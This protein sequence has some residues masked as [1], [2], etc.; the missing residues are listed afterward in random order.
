MAIS[1]SPS[2]SQRV[3][4][5]LEHSIQ[6]NSLRA[7]QK[8][9]EL[10]LSKTSIFEDSLKSFQKRIDVYIDRISKSKAAPFPTNVVLP[11]HEEIAKLR[12]LI[13]PL[14]D[15]TSREKI[16]IYHFCCDAIEKTKDKLG[17]TDKQNILDFIDSQNKILNMTKDLIAQILFLFDR[18]RV[19]LVKI[20]NEASA[21][22]FTEIDVL[23][24]NTLGNLAIHPDLAIKKRKFIEIASILITQ[25]GKLNLKMIPY[26]F[27]YFLSDDLESL[28]RILSSLNSDWQVEFDAI[29]LSDT[30]MQTNDLIRAE[31]NLKRWD[32]I[33][34]Y[35]AKI[36][37][38]SNLLCLFDKRPFADGF[39][40][41]WE[42]KKHVE[43]LIRMLKDC[44]NLLKH[45]FISRNING[46]IEQF[47]YK[48]SVFDIE[49]TEPILLCTLESCFAAAGQARAEDPIRR[50]IQSCVKRAL[51]DQWEGGMVHPDLPHLAI[52]KKA[53]SLF[54][55]NLDR[56]IHWVHNGKE[57]ELYRKENLNKI[58]ICVGNLENFSDLIILTLEQTSI[59][60][61]QDAS[62]KE[63]EMMKYKV[64]HIKD[65]IT[66]YDFYK[67]AA[68]F[69]IKSLGEEIHYKTEI[70]D[71]M[72]LFLPHVKTIRAKD[73]YDWIKWF[74]NFARWQE[75]T[76]F[77]LEDTLPATPERISSG[78]FFLEEAQISSFLKSKKMSDQWISERLIEPGHLIADTPINFDLKGKLDQNIYQWIS[79][80]SGSVS[81]EEFDILCEYLSCKN[82][83]LHE[84][85]STMLDIANH[86]TKADNNMSYQ[87]ALS[88]D[89]LLLSLLPYS[90]LSNLQNAAI[91]FA[92]KNGENFCVYFNLR[93]KSVAFGSI[94][95]DQ[96][97]L[98]QLDEYD[99]SKY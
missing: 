73:P 14:N 83:T 52:I 32:I 57:F 28:R 81:K 8:L 27:E 64:A 87:N 75:D 85:A 20:L 47:F 48:R 23:F 59:D 53:Q 60:F 69:P 7:A 95:E 78:D 50:K 25:E 40:I 33:T 93:T 38:L 41:A 88:F 99:V 70:I 92:T 71:E 80:L 89:N 82:V 2:A 6:K 51:L 31:L 72:S 22:A 55:K 97:R 90:I 84:Y 91:R 76:Q 10:D 29:T 37:V 79:G 65:Y 45:G 98:K 46:R 74:L 56:L 26:L 30:Q 63:K 42:T 34:D 15:F 36:V 1:L 44:R 4:H 96:S 3:H 86:L 9:E 39:A 68:L 5:S 77:Y 11:M 19:K 49:M 21:N 58:G 24:T 13:E 35:H 43:F 18:E 16:I 54:Y 12:N 62:L 94:T 66:N 61:N 17:E 67:K